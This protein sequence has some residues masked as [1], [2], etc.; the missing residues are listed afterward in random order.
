[1]LWRNDPLIWRRADTGSVYPNGLS[2]IFEASFS[3]KIK[4]QG[5]LSPELVISRARN[6]YAAW[7]T[8]LLQ[9]CCNDNP[10][11]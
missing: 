9:S 3:F 2:N 8:D 7:I 6:Q 11:T 5:K 1:M 4:I 10:V